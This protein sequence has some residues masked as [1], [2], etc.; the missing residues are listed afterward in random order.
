[1]A[2]RDKRWAPP[3]DERLLNFSDAGTP[4]PL[5]AITLGRTRPAVERRLAFTHRLPSRAV[6]VGLVLFAKDRSAVISV[7]YKGAGPVYALLGGAVGA[8]GATLP[9]G[10]GAADDPA[11]RIRCRAFPRFNLLP[12]SLG[13]QC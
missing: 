7:G 11:A 12:C 6:R 3:D 13:S 8:A 10:L 9:I 4:L 5:I 1:M 2:K